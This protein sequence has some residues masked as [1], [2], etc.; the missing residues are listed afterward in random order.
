VESDLLGKT[1]AGRY[2]V[3]AVLGRGG[4]GTV[5]EAVSTALGKLVAVKVLSR[6]SEHDPVALAR[7][8]LEARMSGS[9]GHPNL[10]EVYDLGELPD[11]RPFLV[12]ERLFGRTLR[13]VLK[14]ARK[15][16]TPIVTDIGAQLLA[17]L[18]MAHGRGIVHRDVKPDNIFVSG[19][20]N[21]DIV[22][23]VLDFGIAKMMLSRDADDGEYDDSGL[24]G[25]GQAVG[26]PQYMAP[27]QISGDHVSDRTDVYAAGLVL[28]EMV[29]LQRPF[30]GRTRLA[31]VQ[32]RVT[33]PA[34]SLLAHDSSIDPKLAALV[35][36]MLSIEQKDRPSAREA[37]RTLLSLSSQ[38]Q[39][40][41][42]L[43]GLIQPPSVRLDQRFRQIASS[44]GAFT[45]EFG[46]A[47]SDDVLT[48]EESLRLRQQLSELEKW[49]RHM[50]SELAFHSAGPAVPLSPSRPPKP[51][52]DTE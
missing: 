3:R 40:P 9:L 45:T 7:F 33:R 14:V 11:G 38:S 1:V 49:C 19:S 17:G 32:D 22:V 18:A 29:A 35:A 42:D 52:P 51:P 36:Q 25:M 34:P 10:C 30:T 16:R 20:G 8:Q 12:M 28:Y 47:L 21:D 15:L 24:T 44:F 27:E 13:D 39:P 48:P 41:P 46:T 23:K 2:E 4:V 37:R 6:E 43:E 50:R 31:Q 26:T 5:Y